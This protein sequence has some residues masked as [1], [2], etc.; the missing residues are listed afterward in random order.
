[1]PESRFAVEGATGETIEIPVS[2]NQYEHLSHDLVKYG[3]PLVT[4]R[5]AVGHHYLPGA[6]A[7]VAYRSRLEPTG[8]LYYVTLAQVDS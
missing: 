2:A 5:I 6:W 4:H 7:V 1:M 8:N 3:A